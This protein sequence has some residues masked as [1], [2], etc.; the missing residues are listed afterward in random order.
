MKNCFTKYWIDRNW[1]LTGFENR[2]Y[3]TFLFKFQNFEEKETKMLVLKATAW[4]GYWKQSNFYLENQIFLFHKQQR[5]VWCIL[6]QHFD[7]FSATLFCRSVVEKQQNMI[8]SSVEHILMSVDYD[9]WTHDSG[10]RSN[11]IWEPLTGSIIVS[12]IAESMIYVKWRVEHLLPSFPPTLFFKFHQN[13]NDSL[14]EENI[15]LS[16]D[17]WMKGLYQWLELWAAG[18]SCAAVLLHFI[19][20][21]NFH[22]TEITHHHTALDKEETFRAILGGARRW[23][24]GTGKVLNRKNFRQWL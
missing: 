14:R 11:L 2:E 20:V 16:S 7:V 15:E 8:I 22:F 13:L 6:S 4:P 23:C 9:C 10:A 18:K 17:I 24:K 21:F 1:Q 19:R 12:T 3:F 5:H